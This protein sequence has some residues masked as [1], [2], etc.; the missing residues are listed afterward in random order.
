MNHPDDPQVIYTAPNTCYC[1][2]TPEQRAKFVRMCE[3]VEARR[4]PKKK[5]KATTERTRPIL[6]F[7]YNTCK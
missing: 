5:P 1:P 4:H 3:R 2:D 7:G 6:M